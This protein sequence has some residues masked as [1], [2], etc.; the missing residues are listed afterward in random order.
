MK[1]LLA[2]YDEFE[3]LAYSY[4]NS[5]C[6]KAFEYRIINTLDSICPRIFGERAKNLNLT[7][8]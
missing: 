7:S 6:F 8:G 4:F 5:I 3:K 1:I 2:V